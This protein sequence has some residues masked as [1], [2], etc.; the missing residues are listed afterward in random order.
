[1]EILRRAAGHS[2]ESLGAAAGGVSA[3][4][5]KRI[6]RGQV[7]PHRSTIAA[8]ANALNCEPQDIL[9]NEERAAGRRPVQKASGD[10]APHEV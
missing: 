9:P 8:L 7:Q 2:R 1:M 5:V 4:T 10:G 6:E 3:A